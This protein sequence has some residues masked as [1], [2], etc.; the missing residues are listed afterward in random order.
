MRKYS[1]NKS[2]LI[3]EKKDLIAQ[4]SSLKW[5]IRKIFLKKK[6]RKSCLN[7]FSG[8]ECEMFRY[9]HY[10]KYFFCD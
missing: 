3:L 6:V 2:K 10:N 5:D 8:K 1:M 9:S 4:K 7:F